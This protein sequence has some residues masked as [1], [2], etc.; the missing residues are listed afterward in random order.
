MSKAKNMAL[1]RGAAAMI[2]FPRMNTTNSVATISLPNAVERYF[3]AANR[4]DPASAA[5]CFT[6]DAVV[7][8]EGHTHIGWG[9]INAWVSHASEKY[10][11]RATV[12][13]ASQ[14]GDEIEVTVRVTG[15]FPGSPADL[16]FAFSLRNDAIAELTI[17]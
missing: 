2:V 10:R 6:P 8:D 11:P 1:E 5:A 16:K 3:D 15:D 13:N 12:I 9:A 14:N 7:R 4:L 17:R